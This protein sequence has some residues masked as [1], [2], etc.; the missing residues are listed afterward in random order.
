MEIPPRSPIKFQDIN[1][2]D[3]EYTP[4]SPTRPSPPPPSP[5]R[6]RQPERTVVQIEV[7]KIACDKC[8]RG[9]RD[10]L[11]VVGNGDA[12]RGCKEKKYRCSHCS[13]TD[14]ETMWVSRPVTRSGSEVKV[15]QD[16]KG[17]KRKAVSPVPPIE[18]EVVKVERPKPRPVKAKVEKLREQRVRA[19]GSK[20]SARRRALPKSSQMVEDT[21]GEEFEEVD[22][23]DEEMEV[24]VIEREPKPKRAR[25]RAH[26]EPGM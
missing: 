12:C 14:L 21:S 8:E 18:R 20:P 24:D 17:K 16:T 23:D 7:F 5:K 11:P 1:D 26:L 4:E 3:D 6:R 13:R 9:G 15:V 25:T 22:D 19:S 10:C 2:D